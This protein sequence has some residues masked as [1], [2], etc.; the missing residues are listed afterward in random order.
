MCPRDAMYSLQALTAATAQRTNPR[1]GCPTTINNVETIAS[2]P[3]ILRRG[4]QVGRLVVC[5]LG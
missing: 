3:A 4:P 1:Y 2:V 5:C